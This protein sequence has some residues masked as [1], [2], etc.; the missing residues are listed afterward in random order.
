ME[1]TD[2]FT[3]FCRRFFD[4]NDHSTAAACLRDRIRELDSSPTPEM[5]DQVLAYANCLP[6]ADALQDLKGLLSMTLDE[7]PVHQRDQLHSMTRDNLKWMDATPTGSYRSRLM[8]FVEEYTRPLGWDS[9]E[10]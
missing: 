9:V 7:M 10:A 3:A 5:V 4:M 1:R 8:L 2:Y 6:D